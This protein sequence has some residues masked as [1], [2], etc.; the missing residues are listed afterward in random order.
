MSGHPLFFFVYNRLCKHSSGDESLVNTTTKAR[1]TQV[2]IGNISVE[3]L[4]L[5]D[6]SFGIGYTQ[7]NSILKLENLNKNVHRAVKRL[8]GN[9]IQN[10]TTK[11][12]FNNKS[13]SYLNIKEFERL[14]VESAFKGN[15]IAIDLTRQLVGLSLTQLWSDA[16]GVKFEKEERVQYLVNRQ[17]HL[18]NFH[19]RLTVWWKKDGCVTGKDYQDRVIEFKQRIGLPEYIS[20]D[21]YDYPTLAIINTKETRYSVFRE[22][23][24]GHEEALVRL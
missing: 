4:M 3:G 21:Q 1:V 15:E 16:F 24:L 23:G 17:E 6:G 22:C 5:P 10:R 2:K 18:K 12:E 13:T 8:L 14:L 7:I 11:S 20:V 19:K 9:E